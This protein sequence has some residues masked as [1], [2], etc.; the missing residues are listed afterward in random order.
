ML[1]QP[2]RDSLLGPM[3]C[4]CQHAHTHTTHCSAS[5]S[6]QVRASRTGCQSAK[7]GHPVKN[8]REMLPHLVLL[9]FLGLL[10]LLLLGLG[11]AAASSAATAATAA[12]TQPCGSF[13]RHSNTKQ[14]AAQGYS[15]LPWHADGRV[16]EGS[17]LLGSCGIRRLTRARKWQRLAFQKHP[18]RQHCATLGG[19]ANLECMK[20]I[21]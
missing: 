10:L 4:H 7:A 9:L 8:K 15:I 2:F 16:R 13:T 1:P 19:I 3:Q 5:L 11:C 14:L 18:A 12:C 21:V 17:S 6:M 20:M